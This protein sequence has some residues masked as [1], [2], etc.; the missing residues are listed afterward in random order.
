LRAR[1][2][3]P[4]LA[5]QLLVYPVVDYSSGTP[6][7]RAYRERYD[8]FAGQR[9]YG[10]AFQD[11]VRWM[12]EQYIPDP[13]L[14]T[15]PDAAPMRAASLAD[16]PRALVFTAEHDLFRHE[17]QAYARRLRA[18]GVPAELINYPGQVHGFLEALAVM[19]DAR[20]AIN[21]SATAIS[22]AFSR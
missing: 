5:L 15:S 10:A 7:Y 16:L 3:G 20:D 11:T 8:L 21:R 6:A 22:A 14:R 1:D 19:D 4:D 17:D 2:T 12:W 13:A 9:G 18:D